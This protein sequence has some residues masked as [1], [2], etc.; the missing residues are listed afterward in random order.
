ML[1]ALLF[2]FKEIHKRVEEELYD[3]GQIIK[4]LR[5]AQA[6]LEMGD[7]TEEEYERLEEKLMERL[8]VA[9][10]RNAQQNEEE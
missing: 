1:R 9:R 2:I 3:E 8:H 10:E 4:E 7:I 6:S 5:T